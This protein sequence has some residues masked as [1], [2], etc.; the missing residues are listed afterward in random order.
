M[1]DAADYSDLSED[2]APSEDVRRMP[3]RL[4]DP[5]EVS[6][7]ALG[8]ALDQIPVDH[9]FPRAWLVDSYGVASEVAALN[10]QFEDGAEPLRI[11]IPFSQCVQW[12]SQLS[13]AAAST[14]GRAEAERRRVQRDA[15]RAEGV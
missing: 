11:P 4:V 3:R 12:A 5:A 13:G 7:H 8:I 2:E 6:A 14:L 15:E 9:S 1:S 10:I